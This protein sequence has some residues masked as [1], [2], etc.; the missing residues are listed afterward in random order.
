MAELVLIAI[1]IA[2]AFV[3]AMRQAPLWAWALA[4]AAAAYVWRPAC[5]TAIRHEPAHLGVLAWLPVIVLAGLS[6]PAIRRA[7][8]ITPALPQD[9]GHPAQGLRHRA[10]GAQCR[11]HRLR[12]RAVLGPARLGEAARRSAHHA[13]RGGEGVPRRADQRALPHG[14]RLG[15]PPQRQGDPRGGLEL[16]QEARL[17]RHAHLQ[18]ARRPGLLAAGAVADPGSHRL[19]LARH[20]HHRHGAELAGARRADREVRHAR[21][22][23][24]LPAAPRQGPRGALLRADRADLRLRRRHHARRRLRD[25]GPARRQGGRGHP[26][27]LGEALHHAGAA[28]DA[29]RPRLA[30]HRHREPAGPRRGPRHHRG[31]GAGRPSRRRDRPPPSALAAP[32]SRTG[33]SGAA[34]CSSPSIG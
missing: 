22:E 15:H 34:T 23:A 4:L 18:G 7:A 29:G 17:P 9:Q 21:A 14:Q 25:Q 2:G 19:A 16:R 27:L 12:C 28:G 6:V 24:P 11:H 10:G 30:R 1:C 32:P 5:C 33:P 20:G 13:D 8:L 31:A 26:R 3:L